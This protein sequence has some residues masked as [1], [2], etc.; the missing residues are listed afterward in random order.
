M[1]PHLKTI[2]RVTDLSNEVY[3]TDRIGTSSRV[4]ARGDNRFLVKQ[5]IRPWCVLLI[6]LRSKTEFLRNIKNNFVFYHSY[7]ARTGACL[8]LLW[9]GL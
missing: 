6:N 3:E 4:D 8:F 1:C 7:H 9:Y 2:D 5:H